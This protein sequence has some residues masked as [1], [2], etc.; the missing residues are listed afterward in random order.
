[1]WRGE[2]LIAVALAAQ[3]IGEPEAKLTEMNPHPA[4]PGVTQ[5]PAPVIS[6]IRPD[7]MMRRLNSLARN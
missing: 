6:T 2:L 5:N 1:M 3:R 7:Q 4:L